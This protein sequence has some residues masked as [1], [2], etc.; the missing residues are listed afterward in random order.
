MPMRETVK[1]NIRRGRH[2]NASGRTAET[3]TARASPRLQRASAELG[4]T[5]FTVFT[6]KA[7]RVS[8]TSWAKKTGF[9]PKK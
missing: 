4:K 6:V 7:M 1:S 8:P 5:W 2:E 3:S 9:E